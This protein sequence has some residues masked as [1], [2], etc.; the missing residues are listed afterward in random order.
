MGIDYEAVRCRVADLIDKSKL[1]N[2]DFCEIY[3]PEKCKTSTKSNAENYISAIRTG[4]NYPKE[5][6]GPVKPELDHLQNLIDSEM[7]PGL[8]MNYLLYGEDVPVIENKTIDL[9]IR[10]WTLADFCEFILALLQEYPQEINYSVSEPEKYEVEMDDGDKIEETEYN[11]HLKF[12]EMDSLTDDGSDL[13]IALRSFLEE[14][15]NCKDITSSKA[16]EVAIRELVKAIRSDSRYSNTTLNDCH[17]G[18]RF[19]E[20]GQYGLQIKGLSID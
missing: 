15:S 4:R 11:L 9:D 16:R 10:H 13:G 6:S 14:Y 17:S 19:T 18:V 7:F 20:Y 1:K 5:T 3:A 2:Y 12:M 8:T